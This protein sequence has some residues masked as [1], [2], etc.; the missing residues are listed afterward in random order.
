MDDSNSL[1]RA[2][3]TEEPS[4]GSEAKRMKSSDCK[5]VELSTKISQLE[6]KMQRQMG[7]VLCTYFSIISI[8]KSIMERCVVRN[9]KYLEV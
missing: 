7:N 5:C 4:N 2:I 1:K 3:S 9:Q 8:T 6:D